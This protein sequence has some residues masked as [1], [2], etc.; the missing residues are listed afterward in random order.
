[1]RTFESRT[2][3]T[4]MREITIQVPEQE[5]GFLL[6]LIKSLGFVKVTATD[7]GDTDEAIRQNLTEAFEEVKLIRAGKKKGTPLNEFLNEL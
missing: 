5:Y 1:M 4:T 7:D 3:L 6:K 2:K